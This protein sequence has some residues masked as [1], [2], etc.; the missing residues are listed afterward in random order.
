MQKKILK[1]LFRRSRGT[2]WSNEQIILIEEVLKF[3]DRLFW[4]IKGAG[5]KGKHG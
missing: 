5:V 2:D 1:F 3:E 4:K